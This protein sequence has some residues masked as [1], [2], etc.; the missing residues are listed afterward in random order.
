MREYFAAILISEVEEFMS[1]WNKRILDV[2]GAR[3]EFCKVIYN[4]RK[5]EVINLDRDSSQYVWQKTIIG[6]AEDIPSKDNAFDLVICRGVLEHIRQ[7]KQQ[8]SINELFRVTKIGGICYIMIP[9]WYNPHA[10][11][12]LK[13]FHV[14]PFYV[15]KYLRA[16][17]FRERINAESFE[18]INLFPIT[19]KKMLKMVT[20]SGF[21]VMATKDTHFRMHFLTKIPVIQEI[22]VPSVSFIL[23]KEKRTP[24][25]SHNL[26]FCL[27]F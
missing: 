4:E 10:G 15:A 16:L 5:G 22:A 9:P 2:G 8:Q 1:L 19:F 6:C 21:K 23:K 26:N 20:I 14:L 3:G 27:V 12:E 18:D 13:P 11:H 25:L 7:E 24:K 17:I